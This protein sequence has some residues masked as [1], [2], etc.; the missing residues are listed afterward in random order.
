MQHLFDRLASRLRGMVTR[1]RVVSAALNPKRTLL[2]ISGLKGEVK[3][4]IELFLPFGMSARPTG[5][6]DLLLL[7]V[8]GS[9]GHLVA[10]FADAS[11]LR[12][13]DLHAGEFGFRDQNGQQ[14]VFRSDRLE[15]TTPLKLVATVS[16]DMDVTVS[17]QVNL[18]VTGK[19]VAAASEFDLT[20]NLNVTGSIVARGDIS[21]GVRSMAGDRSIYNNHNHS[22]VTNG[23]S[24]TTR[25]NQPQ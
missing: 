10:L 18:N 12:I 24:T 1:G 11:D 25:T 6:E 21:D 22:G 23:S 8:G 3:T 16:G 2:Q 14:V 17:G 4:G 20:G 13:R 9:R 5:G 7:Q 19:V 15:V